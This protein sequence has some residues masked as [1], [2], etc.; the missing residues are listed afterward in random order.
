M[1]SSKYYTTSSAKCPFYK[2]ESKQEICCSGI[3]D[4]SVLHIAFANK[5]NKDEFKRT[6]C[7][8]CYQKC[9]LFRMI[10]S[11]QKD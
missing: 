8:R 10:E 5:L 3:V 6:Y 11:L 4:D 2:R 7:A 1:K 9:Q